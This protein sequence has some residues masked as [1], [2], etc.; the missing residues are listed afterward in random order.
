[1][2]IKSDPSDHIHTGDAR[3]TG[4]TVVCSRLCPKTLSYVPFY[5]SDGTLAGAVAKY[6]IFRGNGKPRLYGAVGKAPQHFSS[7]IARQAA[8]IGNGKLYIQMSASSQGS[9]TWCKEFNP[10]GRNGGL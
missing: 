3:T 9:E 6:G 8:G 1:M 10:S 5:Y 4:Y 7:E 2:L